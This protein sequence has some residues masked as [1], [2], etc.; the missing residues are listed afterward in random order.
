MTEEEF[1]N[2]MRQYGWTEV[3]ISEKIAKRNAD[4]HECALLLPFELYLREK[5]MLRNYCVNAVGSLVDKEKF[6]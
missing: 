6:V 5:D 2:E 4:S 1:R 3:E